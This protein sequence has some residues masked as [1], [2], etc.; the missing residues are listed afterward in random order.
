MQPAGANYVGYISA[1]FTV[2]LLLIIY[3]NML[4]M[5][6]CCSVCVCVFVCV[7]VLSLPI[8]EAI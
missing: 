3:M 2:I 1:N 5:L 6:M 8:F 4:H 7:R